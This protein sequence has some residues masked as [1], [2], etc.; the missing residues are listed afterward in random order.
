MGKH[1]QDEKLASGNSKTYL[2][3]ALEQMLAAG[4][5]VREFG[6]FALEKFGDTVTPYLHEFSED[7]SRGR[8]KI[9]GLRKAAKKTILGAHIDLEEREKMIREAAYLRAERRGFSAGSA[10]EDWHMAEQEIDQR[11]AKA[12]GLVEKG[13]KALS[14]AGG[15]IEHELDDIRHIVA[16]W[17]GDTSGNEKYKKSVQDKKTA[18]DKQVQAEPVKQIMKNPKKE[19]PKTTKAKVKTVGSKKT[20]TKRAAKKI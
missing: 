11:L 18:V 20:T 12:S 16:G 15:M 10:D 7:I 2:K 9:K 13:H 5:N 14:S 1:S 6:D 8:I 19:A 3:T 17:L 4:R